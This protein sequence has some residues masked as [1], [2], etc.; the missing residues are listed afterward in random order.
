M[1][2]DTDDECKKSPIHMIQLRRYIV[3]G[4]ST[5]TEKNEVVFV[6]HFLKYVDSTGYSGCVL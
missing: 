2:M 1:F 4:T 6:F 3:H 5:A